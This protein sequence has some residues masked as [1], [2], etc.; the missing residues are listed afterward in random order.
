M[1]SNAYI[2]SFGSICGTTP[3]SKV[4]TALINFIEHKD[5][6]EFMF[7]SGSVESVLRS[8]VIFW[9]VSQSEMLWIC[10]KSNSL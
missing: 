5:D 10:S 1:D 2:C 8:S 9:G 7:G 6:T 3:Y 4:I